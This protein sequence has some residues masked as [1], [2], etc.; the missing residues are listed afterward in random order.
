MA[1][2]SRV[3]S[4]HCHPILC[5]IQASTSRRKWKRSKILALR[6]MAVMFIWNIDAYCIL[7]M[8]RH[9]FE[10]D[11]DEALWAMKVA[12]ATAGLSTWDFWKKFLRLFVGMLVRWTLQASFEGWEFWIYISQ[13][14]LRCRDFRFNAESPPPNVF[15]HLLQ[16]GHFG[17]FQSDVSWS[18]HLWQRNG[19]LLH[20][21]WSER[22]SWLGS[23]IPRLVTEWRWWTFRSNNQ[24][25][26][27]AQGPSLLW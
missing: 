24:Q 16:P 18:N 4:S 8:Y 9:I 25:L 15:S 23:S 3:K 13:S 17:L 2:A 5:S 22:R 10:N 7:N 21:H 11:L 26:H 19:M 14:Q 6:S 1:R 20:H 27:M 12:V